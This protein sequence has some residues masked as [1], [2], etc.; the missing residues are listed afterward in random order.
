MVTVDADRSHQRAHLYAYPL[1]ASS[2]AKQTKLLSCLFSIP[3]FY[4]LY[5]AVTKQVYLNQAG[6]AYTS[7]QQ[8]IDMG[9][10]GMLLGCYTR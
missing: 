5:R 8:E 9:W 4:S 6:F 10:R 2:S 7:K 1:L 3:F